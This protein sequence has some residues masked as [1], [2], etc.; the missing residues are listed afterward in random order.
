[1]SSTSK[2]IKINANL[3]LEWVYDT[4]NL[5]QENYY[6]S[7]NL[8]INNRG[9]ISQTN[10]YLNNL[11]N[12]VF[13]V[14]PVIKKY[15]RFDS[16]K[17]NF[18]KL[19]TYTTSYVQFDKL[20]LYLPTSYSFDDNDYD[21]FYIRVY[22]FDYNNN[23][24]YDL[25]SY[26]YDDTVQNNDITLN[27]EFLY[28]EQSWGKY[29]MMDIPS[30]DIISK[31]RTSSSST[32]IPTPN[33]IN[34]NLT[35]GVG[36]SQTSPIFIEFAF[37]TSKQTILGN[38]YFFLSDI[39]TS[40]ISKTA[41]YADLAANI[42]ESANGDYFEIYGSY[43]Q[44][45][46]NLDDFIDELKSKGRVVR[47]EYVISLYEENILMS[48][49]TILVTENYSKKLLYRPIISFSN[50]TAAIDVEMKIVDLVDN[51]YFSKYTSI[52]LTNNLFKYG[53]RLVQIDISNAYRPKIYNLKNSS[54][55][56]IVTETQVPD[57]TLTK[58]N[59]PVIVEREKIMVSSTSSNS[60]EYKSMGL[61]EIILNPFGNTVKFMLASD[62]SN[63]GT[64]TP[65][66][67]APLSENSIFTLS[68]KSDSNFLEKDLW[69]ESN[70]NNF[71]NGIIL[72][73]IEEKDL[74]TINKIGKNNKNYYITVKSIKTGVRSL[75]YSGKWVNY[76]D[77]IFIDRTSSANQT[78]NSD[79]LDFQDQ[80][81]TTDELNAVIGNTE[82]TPTSLPSTDTARLTKKNNN[83][84]VFLDPNAS[85]ALF[86][87][88]LN[89]IKANIYLR[90]PSGNSTSLT[91]LYLLLNISDALYEDI[92]IQK[93]VKEIIKLEFDL[94]K[95]IDSSD[96][97]NTSLT[98]T[99]T[100][101]TNF[102][103]NNVS[104]GSTIVPITTIRHLDG[105]QV[106]KNINKREIE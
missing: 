1:M 40:S 13:P 43:I 19:E 102:N 92:K 53:K 44:S 56:S 94:G 47:I 4:D 49:Q 84:L 100:N 76:N 85:V 103:T 41:E 39:S 67:L 5:T 106:K 66:N 22:T 55:N 46:E 6:I 95:N 105:K 24:T 38:T 7:N 36:L 14:D 80:T 96:T 61:S 33:S 35:K 91:Y 15:A 72:F 81:L 70:E 69:T 97:A 20:R 98:T 28:D 68:F 32:N 17:Y 58:V 59:Y 3:L 31:Q 42:E 8:N 89:T 37:V 73:K 88:Y 34:T 86:D 16:S 10:G 64:A 60:S 18:L 79:M 78:S 104:S 74:D 25:C 65:Y 27:E 26:I 83:L 2:F 50:T 62:I 82:T 23:K 75:L 12:N 93:G 63:D 99:N 45:N 87:S 51:S 21:G 77:V 29:L 54:V 71:E 52:S 11:T 9:Y 101:I 57:I 30:A 90:K 48:T